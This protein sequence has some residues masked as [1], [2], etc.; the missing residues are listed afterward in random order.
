MK[1]TIYILVKIFLIC[2]SLNLLYPDEN[3]EKLVEQMVKSAEEREKAIKDVSV[4]I[5]FE[6]RKELE[7]VQAFTKKMGGE[8]G[9]K[10]MKKGKPTQNT[11]DVYL[12]LMKEGKM[13]LEQL[14][15]EKN[16]K[17]KMIALFDEE[18]TYN[19]LYSPDD[20]TKLG[21]VH[22]YKAPYPY[23]TPSAIPIDYPLTLLGIYL[24]RKPL[25]DMLRE[26][27][28]SSIGREKLNNSECYVFDI[29]WEQEVKTENGDKYVEKLKKRLWVDPKK[30]FAIVKRADFSPTDNQI[31][32]TL[33][34]ERFEEF[35][36]G[37]WLPRKVVGTL[38]LPG[39]NGKRE[40]AIQRV[41]EMDKLQINSELSDE[42][43]KANLEK[44]TFVYDI[45]T[46]R[47]YQ[48]GKEATD[49]DILKIAKDVKRYLKG[50]IK[51]KDL[52]KL[53]PPQ[54]GIRFDYRCGPNALLFICGI[55]DIQA[56]S[57]ELSKLAN[58]DEKG[59]T[60]L[61]GLKKA[62][63]AKGLKAE[64]VDLTVQDLRKEMEKGKL[65]IAYLSDGHF[66]AVAGFEEYKV[67]VLDPPTILA[68]APISGFD[69]LWNGK[70]LLISK[71]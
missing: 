6:E 15:D 61:A 24:E 12:W 49:E 27:K 7:K 11:K 69:T 55:L 71:Q 30:G 66:V 47:F 65:A 43:F 53:Y 9:S 67:I 29:E 8:G 35:K 40:P 22:I 2:Y 38:F 50:E 21:Q 48:V 10:E 60:S 52:E 18:K 32:Y 26:S 51:A 70:A 34:V 36:E 58:A 54:E 56:T 45:Q 31:F 57:D 42:L 17:S 68:V 16:N 62:A 64:G 44:G 23:F 14:Y 5:K 19:F 37:I 13:R 46:D 28:V 33:E 63:E 59:I 25:S 4:V 41:F 1:K 20:P 39:E 3:K